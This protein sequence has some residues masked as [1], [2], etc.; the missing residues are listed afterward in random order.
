[1]AAA[2]CDTLR[3]AVA[4]A[5]ANAS[6]VDES[7]VIFLQA[8]GDLPAH[9]A[10]GARAHRRRHDRRPRAAD[11]GGRRQRQHAGV[12]GD[13]S[14]STAG[15]I[16]LAVVGGDAPSGDGGNILNAGVAAA[17]PRSAS[18]AALRRLRRRRRQL[19]AALAATRAS[20][21]TTTRTSQR[22]R[23]PQPRRRRR[24]RPL[25]QQHHGRVQP[26]DRLGNGAGIA[27][28][29]SNANTI[30]AHA[31]DDRAQPDHRHRQRRG[32]LAANDGRDVFADGSIVAN[33]TGERQLRRRAERSPRRS[34][35]RT[36]RTSRAAASRSSGRSA[37]R[38]AAR[39]QGGDTDV[40]TIDPA[41]PAKDAVATCARRRR[42]AQRAAAE[43]ARA[44]R[45]RSRRAP[46]RRRSTPAP[47]IR[48]RAAQPPVPTP[49]P[50]PPVP[51]ADAHA[52]ADARR[53]TRDG[54]SSSRC[55]ARCSSARRGRRAARRCAPARRSRW[56]RPSTPRKGEVELTSLLVARRPAA[57]G[58]VPRRHLPR[59]PVAATSPSCTLTEA[60]DGCSPARARRP[61]EAEVAQA[62]GRRQGQVPHQGPL[63]R[64]HRP[65]HELA[66][67]GHLHDHADARHTGQ[68]AASATT[69]Q[70]QDRDRAQGQALPGQTAPLRSAGQRNLRAPRCQSIRMPR[71]LT[72]IPL[73]LALAADLSA[74][75]RHLA[76]SSP[77]PRRGHAP[78][79]RLH[80]ACSARCATRSAP[81]RPTATRPTTDRAAARARYTLDSRDADRADERRGSR[82]AA[83]GAN[84]T[85]IRA[86]LSSRARADG[87]RERDRDAARPDRARR[88]RGLGRPAAT[89]SSTAA[90]LTLNRVRITGGRRTIGRRDRGSARPG[91]V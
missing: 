37:S 11:D 53:S 78:A 18:P 34:R 56:A 70:A 69:S 4:A 63:R 91:R 68:R 79:P 13:A 24:R 49:T 39:D 23:H 76:R 89:C 14:A 77:S 41:L 75:R 83:P 27:S 3:A 57:D 86:D 19:R 25:A 16:R 8:G 6:G 42:P 9:P 90:A 50:A 82:S 7:D 67:P 26:R 74:A 84:A 87:R 61:E 33:N 73:A 29:G 38:G 44:T 88:R 64:G 47:P 85:I 51:T 62:V 65:R 32:H 66:R 72:A 22:R 10:V 80:R 31:R 43:P 45:A 71:R 21:T 17:A 2:R 55:V 40:L 30:V 60:L 28:T 81:R 12:L 59:H 36:S 20:S 46:S 54:R 5:N 58:E 35:A 48:S 1:M 52:G 15:L